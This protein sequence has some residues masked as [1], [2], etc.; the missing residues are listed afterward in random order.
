M[1]TRYLYVF[2]TLALTVYG[3]LVLKWQINKMGHG[4]ADLGSKVAFLGRL[5]VNPWVITVLLSAVLAATSWMVAMTHFTLS[6][7]YPFM[8]LSFVLVL[9]GSA[10]WLDESLSWPKAIGV[11]VIALGIAIGSQ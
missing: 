2:A 4:G 8:G 5:V 9:L 1:I 11:V 3:Q 10:F 6:R 7:A